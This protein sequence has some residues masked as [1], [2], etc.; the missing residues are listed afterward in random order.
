M[1]IEILNMV[2]A[3]CPEPEARTR[4]RIESLNQNDRI[5][6]IVDDKKACESLPMVIKGS[7]CKILEFK[8]KE[9]D[10]NEVFE[11]LVVKL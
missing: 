8:R 7:N 5:T 2:G 9:K 1:S 10:G 3:R 6:V 11:F 4:A